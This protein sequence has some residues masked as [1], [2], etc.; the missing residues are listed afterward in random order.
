MGKYPEPRS[1]SDS[2]L[3]GLMGTMGT[4]QQDMAELRDIYGGLVETVGTIQQDM[5]ELCDIFGG[6]METLAGSDIGTSPFQ[7]VLDR[8]AQLC[9][10]Y[11]H[12]LQEYRARIDILEEQ[13]A[14]R[15]P[16]LASQ[17]LN[18]IILSSM[19]RT[20][21]PAESGFSYQANLGG[22]A[23][24]PPQLD[25][26]VSLLDVQQTNM[27]RLITLYEGQEQTIAAQNITVEGA[28]A[29]VDE[30]GRHSAERLTGLYELHEQRASEHYRQCH[31]IITT[32]QSNNTRS[33]TEYQEIRARLLACE[34]QR[35]QLKENY[36]ALEERVQALEDH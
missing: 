34:A 19:E 22:E 1:W 2:T 6:V 21:H 35:D 27:N 11:E 12:S 16:L 36:K 10:N 29:M 18:D 20:S 15:C 32:A 13:L 9:N 7:L 25:R 24:M 3:L 28:V 5:A 23:P 17:V 4:I 30:M 33:E 8:Y 26:L 14:R 31:A